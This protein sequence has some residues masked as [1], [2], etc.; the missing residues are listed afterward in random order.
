MAPGAK[1]TTEHRL[2]EARPVHVKRGYEL[3]EKL[4]HVTV[5]DSNPVSLSEG[6]VHAMKRVAKAEGA[7]QGGE[8]HDQNLE[9]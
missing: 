4:E 5:V 7:V 2:R 8:D 6:W 1:N 9:D 3:A